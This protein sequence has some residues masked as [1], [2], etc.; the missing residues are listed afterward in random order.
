MQMRLKV[1]SKAEVIRDWLYL[2]H[3]LIIWGGGIY[4]I[5]H[6]FVNKSAKDITLLWV[7]C[8]LYAE[9]V[10]L[11]RAIHSEYWVWKICHIVGAI[12]ITLLLVAVIL[13][14]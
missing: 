10:A 11:P 8:L 1:K 4:Q 14:R 6:I 3:A 13:Y 9:L 2:S 12:L 7:L 5:V